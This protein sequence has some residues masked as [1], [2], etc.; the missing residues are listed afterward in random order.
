MAAVP[1]KRRVQPR[2]PPKIK[3]SHSPSRTEAEP[4]E[5]E[6]EEEEDDETI[7]VHMPPRERRPAAPSCAV[8][9]EIPKL[10]PRRQRRVL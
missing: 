2:D 3:E 1:I 7:V 5:E 6:E 10:C 9:T 4:D 8:S